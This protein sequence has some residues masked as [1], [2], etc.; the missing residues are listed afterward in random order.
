MQTPYTLVSNLEATNSVLDK[1]RIIVDAANENNHE[2]FD[3]FRLAYDPLITF[4]VK[5]V[6]ERTGVNGTGLE[7]QKFLT[8]VTDLHARKLTGKAATSAIELLMQAATNDEWNGWYRRILIKDMRCGTSDT[9]INDIVKEHGR[10]EY[11]IP[12]FS[13]Q[14]A[15]D[16]V[17]HPK[18]LTGTKI[19]DGKYDGTRV[20]TIVDVEAKK[21][22]MVSRN[23]HPLDNFPRIVAALTE[24]IET[25]ERSWV[26]D[27]EIMST[28]FQALMKQLRRKSDV[29]TDD[30]VLH[31]FDVVPLSEFVTGASVMGQRRRKKLLDGFK[32]VFKQAGCI[33]V[34]HYTELDLDS[35]VGQA[36]Y[37]SINKKAIH[38]G[39]EGIMLKDPDA[40]YECK[41]TA[42]WLKV[43]PSITVDLRIDDVEE[44]TGKYTGMLGAIVC[45]GIDNG[46]PISCNVGSGITDEQRGEWYFN[47]DSLIGQIVEIRADGITQN[48]DGTY[49]LRFPRFERFRGFRVGEKI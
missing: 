44:G 5:K 41:R 27:G 47:K 1:K 37:D 28:D 45:S 10:N 20:L 7:W 25:F 19:V 11:I 34:V 40:V 6:P 33:E 23:G 12:V 24:H 43:K 39:L 42:S 16:G 38:E 18:K 4:G 3:G 21:V 8:L 2:F 49:S 17:K 14:L 32:P 35:A 46:I 9:I 26:F 48:Q 31:L 22:S 13:C 36:Q 30:C 29:S 15:K